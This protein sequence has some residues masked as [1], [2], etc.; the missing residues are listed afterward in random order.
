MVIA[1][2]VQVSNGDPSVGHVVIASTILRYT[3]CETD[4]LAL[5]MKLL[6]KIS[7]LC[8]SVAANAQEI[9]DEN[10]PEARIFSAYHGLDPLPPRATGLCGLPP[11][12]GQDGIPVVF[13]AQI[14]GDTVS[15]TAFAV[16][17]SSGEIVTPLCATLR[18]ALEPLEQRTV[19]LIGPFSP[20][21]SLPVGVEIVEQLEDVNGN[22]LVGLRVE[23]VTTL[24]SGPGLVLAER[25]AP[26]TP[27]L[28]GECPEQ[29]A[30]AILL[31]WE[32]GVTGPRGADLA[33]AQRTAYRSCL[34]TVILCAHSRSPMTIRTIMSSLAS[35]KQVQQFR[36][37]WKRVFSTIREMT[38][39]PRPE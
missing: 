23:E 39:I 16:E 7:L 10:E 38:P 11:A 6:T 22:S 19:L 2:V 28:E 18:P 36:S 37:A 25:F 1:F 13:S 27:G 32:G 17:I 4:Y 5:K 14:N 33:E 24:A 20:E 29:T 30:Q 12:G 21:D 15:P 35:L 31:T 3:V 34:I 8:F 26:D 9:P